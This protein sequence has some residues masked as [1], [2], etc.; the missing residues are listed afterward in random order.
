MIE[1]MLSPFSGNDGPGLTCGYITKEYGASVVKSHFSVATN[2][3]PVTAVLKACTAGSAAL[4]S[5][6]LGVVKSPMDSPCD[7]PVSAGGWTVAWP[8]WP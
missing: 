1:N 4:V 3:S 2:C 5:Y 8:P 7:G 6:H